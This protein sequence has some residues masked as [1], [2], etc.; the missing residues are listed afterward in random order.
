M[1]CESDGRSYSSSHDTAPA[2]GYGNRYVIASSARP[3]FLLVIEPP[4]R[5]GPCIANAKRP[6]LPLRHSQAVLS[7][8]LCARPYK[9]PIFAEI[10]CC[11]LALRAANSG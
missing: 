5:F 7:E 10:R 2:T 9:V 8:S 4:A 11:R 6:L 1:P 3:G